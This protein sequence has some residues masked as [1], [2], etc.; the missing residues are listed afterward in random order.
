MIGTA[1]SSMRISSTIVTLLLLGGLPHVCEAE[2][3]TD[4]NFIVEG[5]VFNKSTLR[6]VKNVIVN[7][8]ARTDDAGGLMSTALSDENGP[9]S[10]ALPVQTG[11]VFTTVLG[12]CSTS[13]GRVATVAT[14]PSPVQR[15]LVYIRNLY[16]QMPKG[17]TE[18]RPQ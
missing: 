2:S 4:T 12:D 18:C 6:P 8:W 16:L 9:Y 11:A 7:F 1:K 5:Y 15:G 14:L 13:K 17:I 3:S 10:F